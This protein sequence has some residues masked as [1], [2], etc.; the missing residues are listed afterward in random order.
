MSAALEEITR[1]INEEIWVAI[2]E[3]VKALDKYTTNGFL[4]YAEQARKN[5][6]T[7]IS[8]KNEI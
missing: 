3:S 5:L 6:E 8:I 2:L 1:Q 7:L 4:D